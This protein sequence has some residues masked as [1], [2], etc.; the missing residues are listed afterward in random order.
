MIFKKKH[1]L[2]L[3]LFKAF[4]RKCLYAMAPETQRTINIKT[5]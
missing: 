1:F 4:L 2:N 5:D 3:P